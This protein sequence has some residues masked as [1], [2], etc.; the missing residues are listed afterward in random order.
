MALT[1]RTPSAAAGRGVVAG[2]V[3]CLSVRMVLATGLTG[4]Y[5]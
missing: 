5:N 4:P 2:G 3:D 1:Q